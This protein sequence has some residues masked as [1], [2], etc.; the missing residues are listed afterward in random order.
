MNKFFA[1]IL[2]S[3]V[4]LSAKGQ[5]S[6]TIKNKLD[7]D[8]KTLNIYFG[9]GVQKRV[10]YEIGLA[11]SRFTG[12][13][14]NVAHWGY[15][16][17]YERTVGNKNLDPVHGIKAGGYFAGL[18]GA[19]TTEVKYQWFREKHDWIITPKY[20]FGLGGL[21]TLSY[22]FNISLNE[23][24]FEQVGKHQFSLIFN[25]PVHGNSGLKK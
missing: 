14:G 6:D 1:L 10:Y 18:G 9:A 12:G 22:G 11:R 24:P 7:I 2:L 15:F 4:T 25:L 16:T 17:C 23:Q 13:R 19:I 20:G 5:G 21:I 3:T 8:N